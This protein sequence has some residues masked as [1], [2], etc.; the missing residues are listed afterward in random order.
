MR[1]GVIGINHKQAAIELRDLLAKA[2]QRRFTSGLS[3]HP[4]HHTILLSTCNRTEIYFSSENLAETHSYLLS[5]IRKELSDEFE[6]CLYSFFGIDC[7]HHL[8]RV[9]AG[10]DSAIVGETEIQGQVRAAYELAHR[11]HALPKELHFLFQK[12]LKNGKF[13]RNLLPRQQSGLEELIYSLGKA[14][15]SPYEAEILFVGASQ[16]NINLI[17]SFKL[18]RLPHITL[19][20]RTD[21][22]TEELANELKI[23]ALPF[24]KLTSWEEFDWIILGT[25][26][27][28]PLIDLAHA[29]ADRSKILFDLSVPRNVKG[30]HPSCTL[31]HIDALQKQV[32]SKA[33]SSTL[34]IAESEL[35]STIRRQL[36]K[37]GFKVQTNQICQASA[38]R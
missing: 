13:V 28:M 9:T 34:L 11:H 8:S 18:R 17:R 35:E 20:N 22:K 7:F 3:L 31:Y 26:A 19:T 1:I 21:A 37:R 2:C 15:Q 25:K 32:V 10:L 36:G 14:L 23:R 4:H 30:S 6:Q 38:S 24:S 33:S 27:P 29:K 16:I 12:S 5:V